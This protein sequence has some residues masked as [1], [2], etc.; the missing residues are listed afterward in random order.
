MK[1][2]FEFDHFDWLSQ[3][4]SEWRKTPKS[5]DFLSF[6]ILSDIRKYRINWFFLKRKKTVKVFVVFSKNLKINTMLSVDFTFQKISENIKFSK[7][8]RFPQK[9]NK[10]RFCV[11]LAKPCVFFLNWSSAWTVMVIQVHN[12]EKFSL[13]LNFLECEDIL[14]ILVIRQELNWPRLNIAWI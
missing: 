6:Q 2:T 5:Q 9:R 13:N 8:F 1:F 7:V 10:L 11:P 4:Y 12:V 3:F 14:N